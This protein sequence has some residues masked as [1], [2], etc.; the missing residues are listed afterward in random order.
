MV[1]PSLL[2]GLEVAV[3]GGTSPLNGFL[4]DTRLLMQSL[5]DA[6]VALLPHPERI[7]DFLFINHGESRVSTRVFR[8]ASIGDVIVLIPTLGVLE[9]TLRVLRGIRTPLLR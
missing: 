9:A 8:S 5:T 7:R 4:N 6:C 1:L 3:T 2:S